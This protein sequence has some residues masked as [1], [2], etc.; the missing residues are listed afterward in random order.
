[1]WL[2]RMGHAVNYQQPNGNARDN[3]RCQLDS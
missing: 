1:M 3:Q 2:I